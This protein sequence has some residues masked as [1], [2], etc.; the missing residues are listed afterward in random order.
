MAEDSDT[1]FKV[2]VATLK[3]KLAALES[4][5]TYMEGRLNE[6]LS[7]ADIRFRDE[8]NDINDLFEALTSKIETKYVSQDQFWPV[9]TIIYGCIAFIGTTVLGALFQVVFKAASN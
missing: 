6:K 2:L 9:Q 5:V 3:E 4:R 7:N 1:D 8:V